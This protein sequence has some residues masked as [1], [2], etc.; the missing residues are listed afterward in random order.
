[1]FER[2]ASHRREASTRAR[3]WRWNPPLRLGLVASAFVLTMTPA[4]AA[5]A[6]SAGPPPPTA[7]ATIAPAAL[8]PPG[9]PASLAG[10]PF[11]AGPLAASR[12]TVVVGGGWAN[13]RNEHIG[14]YVLG[15]AH[16]V[17]P[18]WTFDVTNT[19]S[20]PW[21]YGFAYGDYNDCGWILNN[22]LSN[23][24]VTGNSYC[25]SSGTDFPTSQF[26][27]GE[28]SPCCGGTSVAV[29]QPCAEFANDLPRTGGDHPEDY[30]GV[31]VY[32][33]AH[34]QWRYVTKAGGMVM[35]HDQA[36]PDRAG[37]WVFM[38]RGCFQVP[39]P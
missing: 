11:V 18:N 29:N 39:L 22:N 33:P 27:D 6:Q 25:G 28:I 20:N 31:V 9:T 32:P 19:A 26:T 8:P 34:V 10:N 2:S 7:P 24:H 35:V 15:N 14:G 37:D 13:I 21:Y 4:L 1:M 16:G 12:Y 17:S 5:A 38:W 23:D 30:T 36:I 3:R